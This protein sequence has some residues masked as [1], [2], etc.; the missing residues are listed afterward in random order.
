[1]CFVYN[2][3]QNQVTEQADLH[4]VYEGSIVSSGNLSTNQPHKRTKVVVSWMFPIGVS[5]ASDCMIVYSE[6]PGTFQVERFKSWFWDSL[7]GPG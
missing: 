4:G 6:D 7:E 1:M 2:T 3:L 5:F